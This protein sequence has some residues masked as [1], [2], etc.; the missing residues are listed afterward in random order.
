MVLY[1]SIWGRVYRHCSS[2]LKLNVVYHNTEPVV[3][4]STSLLAIYNIVKKGSHKIS[5]EKTLYFETEAAVVT[6]CYT[7]GAPEDKDV[8]KFTGDK[9][10]VSQAFKMYCLFKK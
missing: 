3:I 4:G 5:R 8:V 1:Q 10:N 9:I 2:S 6:Y 7:G